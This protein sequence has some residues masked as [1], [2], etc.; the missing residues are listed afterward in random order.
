MFRRRKHTGF[1]GAPQRGGFEQG[2]R[3]GKFRHA[4]CIGVP[5]LPEEQVRIVFV[6][7]D[8]LGKQRLTVL[9]G[10]VTA[11]TQRLY[12]PDQAIEQRGRFCLAPKV[13]VC[14]RQIIEAP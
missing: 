13:N 3:L 10:E 11:D 7:R 2:A 8:P 1:V 14:H 5:V 12:A 4:K 6:R 9:G